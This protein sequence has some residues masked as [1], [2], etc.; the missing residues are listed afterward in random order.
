MSTVRTGSVDV[1]FGFVGLGFTVGISAGK[2]EEAGGKPESESVVDAAIKFKNKTQSKSSSLI[3]NIKA[4][5]IR[6]CHNCG[7]E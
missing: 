4:T 7:M 3:L 6:L 2:E 5:V 1:G